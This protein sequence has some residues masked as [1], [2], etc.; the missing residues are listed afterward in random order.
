MPAI[1]Q[2]QPEAT[3]LAW[4]DC[5]GLNLDRSPYWFFLK[6]AKV[7]MSDGRAFGQGGEGF[8][9]LNFATSRRILNE[10]LERMAKTVS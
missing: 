2:H 3:Y 9:R 10:A 5:S 4:L 8:L 1:R 6:H 7:A